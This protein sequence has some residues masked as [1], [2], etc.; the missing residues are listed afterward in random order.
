[1]NGLLSST[2]VRGAF[3]GI[4]GALPWAPLLGWARL[5]WPVGILVGQVVGMTGLYLFF[6]MWPPELQSG[7]LAAWRT[8]GL[9]ITVFWKYLMPVSAVAGAAA[10][11]WARR[12]VRPPRWQLIA[13]ADDTIIETDD[14]IIET[15]DEPAP[16]PP[17][18]EPAS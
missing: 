3:A 6:F 11:L 10:T 2:A 13:E 14:T 15:D 1:M 12:S 18:D 7:R 8:A 4:A 16:A 17:A 9:F 5:R